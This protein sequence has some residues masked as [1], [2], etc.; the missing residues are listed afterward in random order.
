MDAAICVVFEPGDAQASRTMSFFSGASAIAGSME[1]RDWMCIW[2]RKFSHVGPREEEEEKA[3]G[4][5]V[6]SCAREE[7]EKNSSML[8]FIVFTRK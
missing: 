4:M 6:F 5:G 7:K 1:E 8:F 3:N 2:P